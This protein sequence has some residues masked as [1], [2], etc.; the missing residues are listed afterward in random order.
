MDKETIRAIHDEKFIAFLKNID[1]Y[2][3]IQKGECKCKFCR[4]V[5][6]IDNIYTIFPEEGKIK[7]VCDS[8]DCM[9]ELGKYLN[10]INK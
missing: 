6:G 3:D 4:Q 8:T 1:I 10:G 7:I 9:V 5:V 2:N